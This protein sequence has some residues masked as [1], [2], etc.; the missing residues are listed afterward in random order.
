MATEG[1]YQFPY[2]K[3]D[4]TDSFARGNTKAEPVSKQVLNI[5]TEE[6]SRFISGSIGPDAKL[7]LGYG[8]KNVETQL[9][10]QFGDAFISVDVD[11]S[12]EQQ[13]QFPYKRIGGSDMVARWNTKTSPFSANIDAIM[14]NDLKFVDAA[15]QTQ[16][17]VS[18]IINP[19]HDIKTEILENNKSD[20]VKVAIGGINFLATVT[21]LSDKNTSNWD[22]VKPI[23][24][25]INFYLFNN[26]ERSISFDLILYAEHKADLSY[27]WSKVNTLA[28]FTTGE[29]S[30]ELG[31]GYGVY[32]NIV[33]LQ[34][35]D[36]IKE[37]GFV[38]DITMN[39]DTTTPW[40]IDKKNQLPFICTIS[41]S[42]Q[43]VT[44][45]EG[46][47]YSFYNK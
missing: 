3:V 38:S 21:N 33:F 27:I 40:E 37:N 39:V 10:Q 16:I 42:F 2:R 30:G 35:G 22:S 18:P 46:S 31:S 36:L 23:G 14:N 28:S 19:Y 7:Q 12:D 45:K 25:G 6:T 20:I 29:P 24:S 44:N 15:I 5:T 34:I 13:Y 17:N 9:G 41:V 26:F 47:Q 4:G 43:V 8:D 32:G 1:K 11:T